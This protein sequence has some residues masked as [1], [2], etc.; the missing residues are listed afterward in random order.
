MIAN[1]TKKPNLPVKRINPGDVPSA[2][3]RNGF[4]MVI[5]IVLMVPMRI[6]HF[7][8]V[9]HLNRAV[10]INL[11]VRIAGASIRYTNRTFHPIKIT[12]TFYFQ[13]F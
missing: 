12:K 8:I 9:Q 6:Q 13:H 4:V 7:I 3:Q 10:K 5:Q 2:F 11:L 1:V